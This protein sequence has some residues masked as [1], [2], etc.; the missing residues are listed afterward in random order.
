MGG[1]KTSSPGIEP[2]PQPSHSLH[3]NPAHPEDEKLVAARRG[4]EPGH[5]PHGCRSSCSFEDCR[6][7]S[8][9]LA[10]LHELEREPVSRPGFE[11]GPGPSHGPMRSATPSG[12]QH[13]REESKEREAVLEAAGSPRSTLAGSMTKSQAPK[14]KQ[15]PNSNDRMPYAVWLL[16]LGH[17]CFAALP[18][19]GYPKG[20]EPLPP[21]SQPGMQPPLHHRHHINQQPD[22]DLN[23]ELCVRTAA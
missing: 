17:W 9:T 10:S 22:Q 2:G 15:I 4:V 12:H 23:P 3:A 14:F 19:Q 8:D 7:R 5:R 18:R 21:G 20:V 13:Q 1:L 16:M 11:P 6:A